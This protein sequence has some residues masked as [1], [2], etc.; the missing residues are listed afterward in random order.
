MKL[1]AATSALALA[2]MSAPATAQMHMPG[3]TMPMPAKPAAKR[4]PSAKRLRAV[5]LTPAR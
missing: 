3:M 2:A 4:E 5:V 1:F